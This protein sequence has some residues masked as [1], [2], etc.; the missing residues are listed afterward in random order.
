ML[1]LL[2]APESSVSTTL[3]LVPVALHHLED[4]LSAT[5]ALEAAAAEINRAA[6]PPATRARASVKELLMKKKKKAIAVDDGDDDDEADT[7]IQV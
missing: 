1:S 3:L 2:A 6:R 4:F 5:R 7:D